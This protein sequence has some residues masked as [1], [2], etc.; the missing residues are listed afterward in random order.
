MAVVVETP[1]SREH[2]QMQRAK[3]SYVT[4]EITLDTFES[5]IEDILNGEYPE[6]RALPIFDG[7]TVYS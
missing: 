5:R 1:Q 2:A 7:Q 3:R 6:D 4:G